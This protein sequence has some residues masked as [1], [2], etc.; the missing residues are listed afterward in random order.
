[1]ATRIRNIPAV[2][3]WADTSST[4]R[5]FLH[6][7]GPDDPSLQLNLHFDEQEQTAIFKMRIQVLLGS[8][9]KTAHRDVEYLYLW[10]DPKDVILL[11]QD[12][13][14]RLQDGVSA[15]LR[16][17]TTCL[18]LVLSKPA[19]VVAPSD[20]PLPLREGLGPQMLNSLIL[21]AKQT[22]LTIHI[23]QH[24]VPDQK[25]IQRLCQAFCNGSVKPH[26]R[27]NTLRDF[28]KGRDAMI[29]DDVACYTTSGVHPAVLTGNGP[30][31]AR[32]GATPPPYTEARPPP[33][34]LFAQPPKKRQRVTA[35]V[36]TTMNKRQLLP[37]A[38]STTSPD[39]SGVYTELLAQQK[40]Q[41]DAF[42]SLQQAQMAKVLACVGAQ[43][44]RVPDQVITQVDKRVKE[45]MATIWDK[46]PCEWEQV[47]RSV[48]QQEVEDALERSLPHEMEEFKETL[49]EECLDHLK[50]DLEE[51]LVKIILPR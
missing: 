1:M 15:V 14:H 8:A 29:I 32:D 21:L 48:V 24:L 13:V 51:G 39:I 35:D 41:M 46:R 42:F 34:S 2:A 28:Y 25:K 18:R 36:S 33:P 27:H 31:H 40:A 38:G 6:L 30:K 5:S 10:I 47:T 12:P 22:V 26:P 44:D 50:N 43:A 16:G 45:E 4:P 20:S 19:Y 49:K 3:E 11:L 37:A 7:A 23:E 17:P 9:E